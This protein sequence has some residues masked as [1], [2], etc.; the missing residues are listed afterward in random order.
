MLTV[1]RN[2]IW[3]IPFRILQLHCW[4]T[5]HAQVMLSQMEDLRPSWWTGSTQR[6]H[7]HNPSIIH[8]E[9]REIKCT[10]SMYSC[11]N[12]SLRNNQQTKWWICWPMGTLDLISL[13]NLCTSIFDLHNSNLHN[14]SSAVCA[15]SWWNSLRHLWPGAG[16]SVWWGRVSECRSR[17]S[18]LP[19]RYMRCMSQ[20]LCQQTI[21]V[22]T[23][24]WPLCIVLLC[25]LSLHRTH[26]R[27]LTTIS[28][29]HSLRICV[30]PGISGR[31]QLWIESKIDTNV[32][33]YQVQ[34]EWQQKGINDGIIEQSTL[35]SMDSWIHGQWS[36]YD[37][38]E[39]HG[40]WSPCS[41]WGIEGMWRQRITRVMH[42]ENQMINW[43][44]RPPG[45][46]LTEWQLRK[47]FVS[48]IPNPPI[49]ICIG[50]S[51]VVIITV[52]YQ[53]LQQWLSWWGGWRAL[54]HEVNSRQSCLWIDDLA[55]HYWVRYYEQYE[56]HLVGRIV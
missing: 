27:W 5:C 1:L 35:F 31:Y 47:I 24:H 12:G 20:K 46:K 6:S 28:H 33:W 50:Y 30:Q 9:I 48:W 37:Y 43:Q 19:L 52:W 10:C 54:A 34:D 2:T 41:P 53:G 16:R 14:S 22:V 8:C 40:N 38:A 44:R 51:G 29:A 26:E 32:N 7:G 17:G 42:A 39:P 21:Y 56:P 25:V 36:V 23:E 13:Q 55:A 11:S 49:S 3:H 15:L 4:Q 18:I 45:M